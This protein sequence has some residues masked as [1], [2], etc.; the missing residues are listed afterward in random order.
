MTRIFGHKQCELQ[1]GGRTLRNAELYNLYCSLYRLICHGT[2]AGLKWVGKTNKKA[3]YRQ[4][5]AQ[6]TS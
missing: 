4:R 1:E 5:I 6:S 3:N 2:S